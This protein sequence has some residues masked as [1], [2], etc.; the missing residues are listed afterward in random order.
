MLS[1]GM[2]EAGTGRVLIKDASLSTM[3]A[4]VKYCYTADITFSADMDLDEVT[5]I[6]QK[7]EIA[8]LKT[9]CE[10]ELCK[11]FSNMMRITVELSR[12]LSIT[13]KVLATAENYEMYRLTKMCLQELHLRNYIVKEKREMDRVRNA[14]VKG[15][16]LRRS[17]LDDKTS[18]R[19]LARL[20]QLSFK[21][22]TT[23]LQNRTYS[24]FRSLGD[25]EGKQ[26]W[27]EVMKS[28]YDYAINP[29]LG[30]NPC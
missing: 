24:T 29:T 21:F 19:T 17:S 2:L 15:R 14:C 16:H 3:E 13:E 10:T 7:Y 8:S 11:R 22:G 12:A 4:V 28:S 18:P 23:D 5:H 20:M 25:E 9:R 30:V 1:V 6:S 27:T 26:V